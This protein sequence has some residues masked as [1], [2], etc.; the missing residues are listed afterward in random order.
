MKEDLIKANNELENMKKE[1]NKINEDLIKANKIISNIN[2]YEI[3]KLK[4]ENN[5]LKQ[6]LNLKD[7]KI[8]E[9]KNKINIIDRPKYDINDIIVINFQA[10]DGSVNYGIKCL[11]TE[12]FA[13]VEEKLYKIYNNLRNTNN[14]FISNAKPVLRFK[15]IDENN[16]KDG[17]I[18][19]LI[20]L[21]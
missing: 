8:N 7:D 9:L 21:E 11:K 14:M 17:C 3:K 4:D 2:N 5:L 6:Q 10:S 12:I 16:I 20:K 15:T 18:V 1:K 13:E 19:Q